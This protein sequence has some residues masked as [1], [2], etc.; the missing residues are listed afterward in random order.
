MTYLCNQSEPFKNLVGDHQG[1]LPVE[2][3]PTY[4]FFILCIC[5]RNLN[6]SFVASVFQTDFYDFVAQR[7]ISLRAHPNGIFASARLSSLAILSSGKQ[8]TMNR[9]AQ[10]FFPIKSKWDAL[11]T[12][13]M[14]VLYSTRRC[15]SSRMDFVACVANCN[16]LNDYLFNEIPLWFHYGKSKWTHIHFRQDYFYFVPLS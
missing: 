11:W 14:Y 15:N 16:S 7:F 12:T 5:Y 8:H 1:P 2:F 13:C 3:D 10:C 6:F 9:S 4:I